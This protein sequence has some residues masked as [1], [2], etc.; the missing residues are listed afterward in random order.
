MQNMNQNFTI[1][2]CF[3]DI[4]Y[5]KVKKECGYQKSG[6]L[7]FKRLEIPKN[8]EVHRSKKTKESKQGCQNQLKVTYG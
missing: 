7:K 8:L 1:A 6:T 4:R 3:A 5:L 2:I